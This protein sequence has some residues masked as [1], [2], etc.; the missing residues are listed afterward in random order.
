MTLKLNAKKRGN[1]GKKVSQVRTK[2]FIPAVLYGKRLE[3]VSL[4]VSGNEF[5]KL[6]K[7]AGESTLVDVLIDSEKDSRKVIIQD[8]QRDPVS[9]EFLH[10]DFYQ[11]N[12]KEKLHAHITLRF[13]G[14]APAVKNLGAVLITNKHSLE[15]RCL[16]S[17]LVAEILIDV[18]KLEKFDDAILVKHL[19]IP[20]G[21]EVLDNPEEA[22]II[23]AESK[24]EK[25]AE[26]MTEAPQAEKVEP[27]VIG[28]KE[29]EEGAKA[30]EPKKEESKK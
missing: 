25:E 10:I 26:K 2:G 23:A 27:E 17:D 29:K 5:L 7:E 20:L 1:F 21:I 8:V 30:D 15:V 3:N 12:L 19:P 16:P 22:V 13:S 9:G 11:V 6:Y 28:K 18:S 24:T 14:E 4:Q